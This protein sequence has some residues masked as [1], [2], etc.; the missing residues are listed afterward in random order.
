MGIVVPVTKIDNVEFVKKVLAIKEEA[1]RLGRTLIDAKELVVRPLR[2]ADLG[3]TTNE[4]TFNVSAGENTIINTRLDDKTLVVIYGIYNL[5]TTP[6]TTELI[7][8]TT[9]KTVEDVYIED[10]YLYDTKATLLD[11]PVVFQP[12]SSPLVKTVA[13]GANTA[14]KLGF[15]GFVVE[16]AGRRIG[17]S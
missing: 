6:V 3:L 17:S 4:W 11:E 2:P 12:G 5:S 16:P 15:L 10:M 9:A 14:E 1:L 8:G 7:F 13:K